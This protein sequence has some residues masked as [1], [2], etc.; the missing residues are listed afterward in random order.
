MKTKKT[1]PTILEI[2][3]K[4]LDSDLPLSTRNE[5]TRYYLL[6]RLGRTQSIIEDRKVDIGSVERPDAEEIAIENN[7]KL[8]AEYK[9]FE[10]LAGVEEVEDE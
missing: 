8:K 9:D 4:I 3:S 10:N 5:I 7:P 6:P 1:K 2:V